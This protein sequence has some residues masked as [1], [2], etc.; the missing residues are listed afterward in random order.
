MYKRPFYQIVVSNRIEKSIRQCE[1]N[2]IDS[3]FPPNRNAVYP[4]TPSCW[5]GD[6]GSDV[7]PCPCPCPC[8]CP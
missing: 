7:N 6:C 4:I 5:G 3:N 8:P 1:S 2:I